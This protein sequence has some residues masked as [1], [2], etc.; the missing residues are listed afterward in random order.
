MD[1]QITTPM[2]KSFDDVI[3]QEGFFD[4]KT[5]ADLWQEVKQL[6]K[7]DDFVDHHGVF[8]GQL[9]SC[10]RFISLDE[11]GPI[12]TKVLNK[13]YDFIDIKISVKEIVYSTLYLPWDIHCDLIR[14]D[15]TNPFYNVLIPLHD[16]PSSTI[17]FNQRSSGYNDFY[18]Y[19]QSNPK[20]SDCCSTEFWEEKL[21]MCWPE[22][23]EYLS[24][25]TLLPLQ[26]AG[27]LIMFKRDLWHSSD[28]FHSRTKEPKHFIQLILDRAQ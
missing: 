12:L 22:D 11:A 25:K 20:I 16:V 2:L 28:N 6:S 23:R 15:S 13:I 18:K 5:I 8:K 26:Q 1:S 21:S 4:K 24:V 19:K 10:Q 7:G 14:E 27:Q 17:I 9:I 3:V